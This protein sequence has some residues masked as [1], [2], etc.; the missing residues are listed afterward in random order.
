M[1]RDIFL[2]KKKKRKKQRLPCELIQ[3]N[4]V[5]IDF[6]NNQLIFLS[7]PLFTLNSQLFFLLLQ[8]IAVDIEQKRH[9]LR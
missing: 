1:E 2:L 8:A 6:I 4:L 9:Y 3:K 7:N 5:P